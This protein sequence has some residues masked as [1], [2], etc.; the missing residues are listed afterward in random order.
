MTLYEAELTFGSDAMRFGLADSGDSI[1]DANF[2]V[3][4]ADTAILR[5]YA[6]IEWCG[7]FNVNKESYRSN[8]ISVPGPFTFQDNYFSK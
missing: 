4:V 5:L 6:F 8:D 2:I 1:E 7:E 3:S